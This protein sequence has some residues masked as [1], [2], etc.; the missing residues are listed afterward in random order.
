MLKSYSRYG[1]RVFL[2]PHQGG[3]SGGGGAANPAAQQGG[4]PDAAGAASEVDPFAAINLDDLDAGTRTVIED[5]RK[6][7]AASQKELKAIQAKAE[8]DGQ[9]ARSFQA[10]HDALQAQLQRLN[11]GAPPPTVQDAAQ[12]KLLHQFEKELIANGV[13]EAQAKVQAPLMLSMMTAYGNQLKAEIG[14]DLSPFANSVM[15]TE[16][17]NAWSQAVANDRLGA[18]QDP[19]IATKVWTDVQAM[20]NARQP[21]DAGTIL[22]LR[23]IYY[24][25]HIEA[26]GAPVQPLPP[27]PV[28][29]QY[30]QIGRPTY[31]GAGAVPFRQLPPDPNAARTVLDPATAAALEAVK[32]NWSTKPQT[33]VTGRPNK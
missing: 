26:G 16:A 12:Q 25:S 11:G 30:P 29:P 10:K 13:T 24:A 17:T 1:S 33:N 23:N 9:L 6:K 3:P 2:D 4:A 19:A 22:N 20:V 5:G 32:S 28:I 27:T 31:P 8:H 15:Q 21:V 18:L 7:F 14:Q